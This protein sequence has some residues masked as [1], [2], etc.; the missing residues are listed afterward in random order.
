MVGS[1]TWLDQRFIIGCGPRTTLSMWLRTMSPPFNFS[2]APNKPQQR[3]RR[4]RR[5][6]ERQIR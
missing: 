3:T 1:K 6:A 2:R 4:R 5:A